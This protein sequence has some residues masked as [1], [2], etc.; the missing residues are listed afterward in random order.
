MISHILKPYIATT[1][2]INDIIQTQK[3]WT[4]I[5][6]EEN[7]FLWCIN[8]IADQCRD[9]L[10]LFYFY[11]YHSITLCDN[12][13]II[14]WLLMSVYK[15]DYTSNYLFL[16]ATVILYVL[17]KRCRVASVCASAKL[18]WVCWYKKSVFYRCPSSLNKDFQGDSLFF[19]ILRR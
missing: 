6:T 1:G 5:S 17:L 13:F 14:R 10:F 7:P 18:T 19:I 9:F 8:V 2:I 11:F 3:H 4:Y 15:L 12:S 16:A